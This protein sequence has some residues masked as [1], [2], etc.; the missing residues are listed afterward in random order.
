MSFINKVQNRWDLSLKNI[1]F[2]F[3]ML[4]G[5]QHR[6]L[7]SIFCNEKDDLFERPPNGLS[8]ERILINGAA[9]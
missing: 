3:I 2:T 8:H 7:H 9:C 5:T 1:V 4:R 6:S